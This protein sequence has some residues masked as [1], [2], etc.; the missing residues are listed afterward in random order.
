M[1]TVRINRK[2]WV[3]GVFHTT[4]GEGNNCGC[5]MGHAVHQ[6]RKCKWDDVGNVCAS[7][8]K[9]IIKNLKKAKVIS[10][11]DT[12]Y[13][14]PALDVLTVGKEK[15]LIEVFNKCGVKLKFYN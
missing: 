14:S 1:K 13:N 8:K 4:D 7:T 5:A 10:I 12:L 3:Q 15:K 11:N 9:G 2:R 6:L